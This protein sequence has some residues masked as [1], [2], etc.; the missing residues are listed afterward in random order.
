MLGAY[1]SRV[2]CTLED[3]CLYGTLLAVF[4]MKGA[5]SHSSLLESQRAQKQKWPMRNG[6]AGEKRKGKEREYARE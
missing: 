5:C 4:E 2:P 6:E 1:K 3:A